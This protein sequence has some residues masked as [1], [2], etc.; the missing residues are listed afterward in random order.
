MAAH[1]GIKQ[2]SLF[3]HLVEYSVQRLLPIIAKERQKHYKRKE[4]LGE[5][6]SHYKEGEKLLKKTRDL[7]GF[8]DP[9]YCKFKSVMN[10]YENVYNNI[11]SFIEKSKIIEEFQPDM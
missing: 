9:I 4:I 11:E 1:L 5:I 2:K 6:T 3:D 8:E 7:L 10:I